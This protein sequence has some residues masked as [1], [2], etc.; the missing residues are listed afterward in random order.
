MTMRKPLLSDLEFASLRGEDMY[1][2]YLQ[3]F[4]PANR[5]IFENIRYLDVQEMFR[6]HHIICIT[7]THRVVGDLALEQASDE[8]GILWL[9]HVSVDERYRQ[10]GIGRQLVDLCID[11]IKTNQKGL[12]VSTYSELGDLYLRHLFT[13][14]AQNNAALVIRQRGDEKPTFAL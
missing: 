5:K 6:E 1:R 14:A 11:H 7:K 3:E 2:R 10:I 8:P 13:R 4:R 12:S 9:K